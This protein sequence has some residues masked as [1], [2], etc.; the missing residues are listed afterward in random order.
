MGRRCVS[1]PFLGRG[2]LTQPLPRPPPQSTRPRNFI[3]DAIVP[4]PSTG[5]R[6]T[7]TTTHPQF[8]QSAKRGGTLKNILVGA[9]S[10]VIPAVRTSWPSTKRH[11]GCGGLEQLQL[12]SLA[13]RPRQQAQARNHHSGNRQGHRNGLKVTVL[14]QQNA[15][16][17][18]QGDDCS[19]Q[20]LQR[21][22]C[23]APCKYRKECR[24]PCKYRKECR[25]PCKYRKERRAPRQSPWPPPA[26]EPIA[27]R[28]YA[29]AKARVCRR[30]RAFERES[31]FSGTTRRTQPQ[32]STL[33]RT[34]VA[35]KG[36]NSRPS[37]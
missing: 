33:I 34:S 27:S 20:H 9:A 4:I 36:R 35:S 21:K 3:P 1:A 19:L 11:P 15:A 26:G 14:L 18:V 6:A 8:G 31:G 22:E 5:T 10:N 7:E 28:S 12:P 25:A 37:P 16:V 17:A 32:T 30:E 23:R 2:C 24:A 13:Q 29:C